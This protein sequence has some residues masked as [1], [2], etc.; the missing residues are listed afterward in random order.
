[1]PRMTFMHFRSLSFHFVL[2][3]GSL[4]KVSTSLY[5]RELHDFINR[6]YATYIKPFSDCEEVVARCCSATGQ[7]T[8]TLFMRHVAIVRPLGTYGRAK[9]VADCTQVNF[10]FRLLTISKKWRSTLVKQRYNLGDLGPTT[11][12]RAPNKIN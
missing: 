11:K 7:R 8:V 2:R 12:L 4:D 5:M 1:M 3:E 9:L 6:A 10:I